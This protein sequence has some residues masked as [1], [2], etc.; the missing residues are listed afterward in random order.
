MKKIKVILKMFVVFILVCGFTLNVINHGNE[1][2]HRNRCIDVLSNHEVLE[3]IYSYL[4][5]DESKISKLNIELIDDDYHV[6]FDMNS[7]TYNF[8][9]H[10]ITGEILEVNN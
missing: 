3:V 10:S 6:S 1:L 8:R 5:I 9:I 2:S 7:M 4:K